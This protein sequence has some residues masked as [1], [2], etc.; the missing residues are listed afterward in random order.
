M[1]ETLT[2]M[3]ARNAPKLMNDVE[4]ATFMKI[5]MRPMTA[6]AS[7]DSTGVWKRGLSLPK[8][9]RGSTPSRPIA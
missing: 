3:N 4:V 9:L 8:K 5:A 2:M 6:M 1:T 7:S